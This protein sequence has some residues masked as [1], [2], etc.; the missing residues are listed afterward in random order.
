MENKNNS[1]T[2]V[3]RFFLEHDTKNRKKCAK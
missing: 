1:E 3:A 2:R